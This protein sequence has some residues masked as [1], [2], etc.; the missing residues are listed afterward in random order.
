MY[1]LT[2][3]L[4]TAHSAADAAA[5]SSA[6][7]TPPAVRMCTF[8]E[9]KCGGFEASASRGYLHAWLAN[10]GT[11][12]ATYTISVTNCRCVGSAVITLLLS[13]KGYRI[14]LYRIMMIVIWLVLAKDIAPGVQDEMMYA[15]TCST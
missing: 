10:T 9:V 1:A 15:M 13:C 8:A 14:I 7:H 2:C 6:H 5:P 12:S 3:L 11:L 4:M